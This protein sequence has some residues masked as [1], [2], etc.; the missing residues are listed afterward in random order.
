MRE[1]IRVI[2]LGVTGPAMRRTF[3]MLCIGT[4]FMFLFI[5]IVSV[6]QAEKQADPSLHMEKWAS[7]YSGGTLL[8]IMGQEVPYL[9][10]SVQAT[11][12]VSLSGLLFQLLTSIN[13][14]DPRSFLGRELPGF[15]LFDG[16]FLVKGDGID[17]TDAP[18]ESPPPT[19][20]MTPPEL[21][22][23]AI[24]DD[25]SGEKDQA[26]DD[27]P[28]QTT[29][30]KKRVFIYHTHW[31]EA[32]LP[33]LKTE[34]KNIANHPEQNITKVGKRFAEELENVGIGAEH[35]AKNY[36]YVDRSEFY[37]ESGKTV[38]AAMADNEELQYFFDIHRDSQRK[39]KTLT[40]IDGEEYARVL[41]V[42]GKDNKN[43]EEN[44]KLA[45]R[46]H[47]TLQEMYPGLSRGIYSPKGKGKNGVYNQDLSPRALLIEV[48]GVDNTFPDLNRTA[49][50]L[51]KA[52]AEI[53]W[54]AERV[55]AEG[56]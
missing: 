49:R 45:K 34:D 54:E 21:K 51:A 48:G 8:G 28:A 23:E 17:Y 5:A 53:Y 35:S 39:E 33:Y 22:E 29:D 30:G 7:G 9:S 18:I 16:E 15:A 41:F 42:V 56:K 40:E 32:F 14:D 25:H 24:N 13:P 6:K 38:R 50:A 4:V 31:Y 3:A 10:K 46:F 55:D 52:F 1:P 11:E 20:D 47:E 36:D 26:A 12:S 2:T 44:Y 19:T 37:S 27:T 43:Y